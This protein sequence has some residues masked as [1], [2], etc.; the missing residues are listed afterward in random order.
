MLPYVMEYNMPYARER[1]DDIARV[2]GFSGDNA[3]A[4]AVDWIKKL[5]REIGITGIQGSGC[6]NG[7]PGNNSGKVCR[8]HIYGQ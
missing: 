7:R 3:A 6:K 5:N 8:K 1:Y 4:M 2:M